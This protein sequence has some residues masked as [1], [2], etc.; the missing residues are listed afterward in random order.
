MKKLLPPHFRVWMRKSLSARIVLLFLGLLLLVQ[1]L[2]FV[3]IR[4]T[5]DGNAR[6]VIGQDLEVGERLL[7]RVLD[8]NA[9]KLT[10][11]ATL[12]AS[13]YG[14][15]SA[16]GSDDAATISSVLAN[17]GERIGASVSALLDTSFRLRA[18]AQPDVAALQP[19]LA[20]LAANGGSTKRASDVVVIDNRPFQFVMVPLRAPVLVGWVLMGFPVD[21]RL[22]DEMRSLSSLHVSLEVQRDAQSPWQTTVSTLPKAARKAL[23]RQNIFLPG[24]PAMSLTLPDGEYSARAVALTEPGGAAV[25]AVLMRSVDEAVAPYQRLQL[26]LAVLTVLSVV[27]FGAGSVL[28][29]RHVTTPLR[30]LAVAAERLGAGDYVTPL[31]GQRRHDEIGDL[32]HAFERMRVS[33]AGQQEEILKLAYWDGLTGLANRLQFR[34]AVIEAMAL[35]KADNRSVAVV[36]L[37]L[38][39]FKHVNDVLGYRFGDLMLKGV[40]ERLSQQAVRNGDLVAR[41]GGDEFAV[42]LADLEPASDLAHTTAVAQRLH[43]AF[44]DVMVLEDHNVDMSASFGMAVWPHHAA[45]ADTLLSRAEVAMYNAKRRSEGPVLYDPAIDAAST[46]TL[47]LLSEL[48][49]AVGH[50]ELRLYLQPKLALDTGRVVGAEALLR[51]QHPTRG[52]VPPMSFIPFAEQTGFI[53]VL[54][55]WVFEES[56]RM[57]RVLNEG[58]MRIVISINL[59]TRDLLDVEL[60]QKFEALLVKHIVPAE[61]FCLEITESAIMDDPQR[62]MNTL[63]RL[64]GLGFKLSIDDFGTGYSSLAYLK[65]LPV[66]ELKIDKSFVLSMEKD[67]NDARIVRS[68]IDLAHGLG[69]TV[70][71]E[72]VENAQVWNLLRD[73]SCDEAQGFH[74]GKPM[75]SNEFVHW[76]TGWASRHAAPGPKGVPGA[77]V[78]LH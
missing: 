59:S 46:Q 51:W 27:V 26:G 39:R 18:A 6:T 38:D 13:D 2:S 54:T 37:D 47:S 65:K 45:D 75:P 68:T 4:A 19:M 12:L 73:L 35:G 17:H 20:R 34:N 55:M 9:N 42:L 64:S 36:M 11:G 74:M 67:V 62:A 71:A 41:L 78:T 52:L 50:H 76:A 40:A 21:Q 1:G 43:Q 56:A 69:L 60:P 49:H 48:R 57:W 70:V 5:I 61:A 16:V 33:V 15:R 66:D 44:G 29:A 72:G 53:R 58:G 7:K 25:S 14:F 28:T 31:G 30:R 10:E 77:N 63:E 3:A 23:E 8:Q 24:D 22:V 32:A